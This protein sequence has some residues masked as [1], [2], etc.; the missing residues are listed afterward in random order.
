MI[1]RPPRST[2]S[3]SSA[4][5]DVYKRQG[6]HVRSDLGPRAGGDHFTQARVDLDEPADHRRVDRVVVAGDPHVV[7]PAQ[8][9]PGGLPDRGRHRRQ[10]AHRRD[11]L[12]TR[13]PV[14]R[15]GN[16]NAIMNPEYVATIVSTGGSANT[17]G[18]TGTT[19]PGNHRSHCTISPAVYVV[20]SAGSGGLNNGRSNATLA[21][22]T[23][24]ECSHPIRSAITD[25]GISGNSVNNRR[26]AGSNSSTR[27]PCGAREY[28][29][30]VSAANADRTVFLANPN[31]RAIA[32]TPT[33]SER[34]NRRISAQSSTLITPSL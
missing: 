31:R 9:D 2:L 5:S 19:S 4:A 23:D 27:E 10:S 3:S 18:A 33:C 20:R 8:P 32:L 17:F 13:S 7:V 14:V 22:N 26:I 25:A 16:S 15:E 24:D 6:P 12:A 34:C 21:R 1:A 11:I 30:G 29:G 28:I